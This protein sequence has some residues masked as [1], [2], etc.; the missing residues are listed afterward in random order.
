LNAET[1]IITSIEKRTLLRI[2]LANR[3]F[4][5]TLGALFVVVSLQF[6]YK[7]GSFVLGGEGSFVIDFLRHLE[8]TS[9]NWITRFGLGGPNLGPMSTSASVLIL[10]L[11]DTFTDNPQ[12]ANFLL[13]FCLF[14]L[15]FLGMYLVAVQVGATPHLAFIVGL[16]YLVNPSTLEFLNSL[17]QWNAFAASLIP[18]LCW[19][20]V[21]YY[22]DNLKLFFFYG[23]TTVLFCHT[24]AN[25]P[26]N[27]IIVISSLLSVYITSLYLNK[28][29]N[30]SEIVKKCCLIMASFFMFNC[31]WIITLFYL[32]RDALKIY[33]ISRAQ[34][35]LV[36][37]VNFAAAPIGKSF[38]LTQIN[39][40]A[41]QNFHGAFYH[42]PVSLLVTLIPL[43]LLL[44]ILFV[45]KVHPRLQRLNLHILAM[46]LLAL[47]F[48]KGISEPLGFIFQWMFANIPFFMIFKTPIEK[49]GLLYTFLFSVLLLF[50]LQSCK[51][52]KIYPKAVLYLS[53]YLLFCGIPF[54][55]GNM[56]AGYYAN[57]FGTVSRKF[58]EK[59]EYVMARKSLNEDKLIYRVLSLP[60]RGNYQ[61]LLD[62]GENDL[63]SGLD[64]IFPN[65]NKPIVAAHDGDL[66]KILYYNLLKPEAEFLLDFLNIKKLALNERFLLWFGKVGPGE[67][68]SLKQRFKSLSH[69]QYGGIRIF[70]RKSEFIPLLLSSGSIVLAFNSDNFSPMSRRE[71]ETGKKYLQE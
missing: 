27:I 57:P 9:H 48:L 46:T 65:T 28:H 25:A 30:F 11:V 2:L 51:S 40:P 6:Y 20:I 59:P 31:W 4:Y 66:P 12:I 22:Q 47:F 15:P 37:T 70:D 53:G 42:N 71:N 41:T 60:G 19:I 36:Q 54:L 17:N 44:C 10:A 13:I 58:V 32:V 26:L 21:R 45:A 34:N 23:L 18:I 50:A 39:P 24:F 69:E 35:W 61:T 29:L 1:S 55:T 68:E 14:Y 64:P 3:F 33:P 56:I 67:P 5:P 8:T 43:L 63:Y 52:L 16:F 7:G 49:F 38:S 62:S